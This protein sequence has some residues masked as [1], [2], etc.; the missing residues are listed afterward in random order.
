M[1]N[2]F[3]AGRPPGKLVVVDAPGYGLRGRVEWGDMV[4]KYM[5]ERE[6]YVHPCCTSFLF[7]IVTH[8]LKRVYI[9]LN[10]KHGVVKTDLEM[11]EHLART[12]AGLSSTGKQKFTFQPIYTKVDDIRDKEKLSARAEEMGKAIREISGLYLPPIP[13][14]AHKLKFGIDDVRKNI[15]EACGL[16]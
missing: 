8:R 10:L 7:L 5:E 11:L 15:A 2:F 1:L 6:E 13:T 16:L 3:R 4:E 14:A 9:L 12:S